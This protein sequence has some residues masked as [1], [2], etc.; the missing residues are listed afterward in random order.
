MIC[1]QYESAYF[2]TPYADNQLLCSL[3]DPK[4]GHAAA[5]MLWASN[6]TTRFS[7]SN[8]CNFTQ[9]IH[10]K[11]SQKV[12]INNFPGWGHAPNMRATHALIAYWNLTP[13]FKILDPPLI[14]YLQC[15]NNK[16]STTVLVHFMMLSNSTGFHFMS[17]VTMG[18][19]TCR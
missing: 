13:L 11:Q 1:Y 10:Q 17:E 15:S 18:V 16:K 3:C 6:T 14:I 5:L 7:N 19:K 12:R 4:R 8:F 9:R 2:P